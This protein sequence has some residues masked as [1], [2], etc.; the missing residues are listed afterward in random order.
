MIC[1]RRDTCLQA[2]CATTLI[3]MDATVIAPVIAMDD[4]RG[5]LDGPPPSG[6][7][8]EAARAALSASSSPAH[9]A[10]GA[11]VNRL[12]DEPPGSKV[13]AGA[14]AG[15]GAGAVTRWMRDGDV[16]PLKASSATPA[17]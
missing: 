11:V 6:T 5:T 4:G 7:A 8:K 13:A 2:D 14:G 12:V 9:R 1:P 16:R 10:G 15:A 3:A 17:A